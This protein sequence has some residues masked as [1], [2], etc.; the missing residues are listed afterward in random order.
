MA[1][2]LIGY[3]MV[4]AVLGAIGSFAGGFV[5]PAIE[6][7]LISG[8][9]T[10]IGLLMLSTGFLYQFSGLK[11]CFILKNKYKSS[12]GAFLY[13]FLTGI[14]F[15]P[16][17]FAAASRAFGTANTFYGAFYFLEFY[18]GTSVFLLPLFG[19]P[20][21]RKYLDKTRI[22]ARMMLLLLGFYFFVFLGIIGLV[23]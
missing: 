12:Y 18:I 1:G 2:R 4:G 7:K 20:L 13:G 10:L 22:I 17:F 3:A 5:N 16:P 21:L 15:C 6:K 9:Y 8:A 14:N 19:I 23:S 11:I